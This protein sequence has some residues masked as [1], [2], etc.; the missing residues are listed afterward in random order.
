MED[1]TPAPSSIEFA[2]TLFFAIVTAVAIGV[3]TRPLLGG[4]VTQDL[5]RMCLSGVAGGLI[6]WFLWRYRKGDY[7]PDH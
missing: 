2:L 5:T 3:Q 6:A 4:T 1:A 7:T